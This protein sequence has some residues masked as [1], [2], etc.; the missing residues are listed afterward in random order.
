MWQDSEYA[1]PRGSFE[2]PVPPPAVDPGSA[3]T[4]TVILSCAWLPYVRGA[5]QQLLLQAT[6]ATSD[7]AI[8]LLTQERVFNLL[9]LFQECA[10]P[11]V[12]FA[13]PY[14]FALSDQTW[15]QVDFGAHFT[16][17]MM[18]PWAL[19]GFQPAVAT[20]DYLPGRTQVW[21]ACTK[22][23][24]SSTIV[25]VELVYELLK[26]SFTVDDGDQTQIILSLA[27]VVVDRIRRDSM[28]DPDG[29]GKSLIWTGHVVADTIEVDVLVA[30]YDGAGGNG[31]GA[32]NQ[33]N[34]FG[35]GPTPC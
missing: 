7:P 33:V 8:L 12:P 35:V 4:Q 3:P 1:P 26:G 9:D 21:M 5:L 18:S 10:T 24:S 11:D 14:D 32:I 30:D 28:D 6:W 31:F 2:R 16:P 23:F 20:I 34:V 27:G 19:G 13:C 25:E 15:G 22:T 17:E 29:V